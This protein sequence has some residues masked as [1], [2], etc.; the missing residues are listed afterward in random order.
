MFSCY[1][2]RPSTMPQL[3]WKYT[4]WISVSQDKNLITWKNNPHTSHT[5]TQAPIRLSFTDNKCDQTSRETKATKW[6]EWNQLFCQKGLRGCTLYSMVSLPWAPK[7][8]LNH[9]TM[10]PNPGNMR[11]NT[12]I[13]PVIRRARGEA[14]S[15]CIVPGWWAVSRRD[16][17]LSSIYYDWPPLT[18]VDLT[19]P[20]VKH[21]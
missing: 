8:D 15:A 12:A 17:S 10:K 13:M 18:R 19:A 2:R 16:T 6:T 4:I 14:E 1:P 20:F 9:M 7:H 5:H 21:L 11:L 3:N